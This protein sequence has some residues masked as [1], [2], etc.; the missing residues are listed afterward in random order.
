MAHDTKEANRVRQKRHRDKKRAV[1]DALV[2]KEAQVR[3]SAAANCINC[4]SLGK[5]C[6]AHEHETN[7]VLKKLRLGTTRAS[8]FARKKTRTGGDL[9]DVL[10]A[11]GRTVGR[12]RYTGPSLTFEDL[13]G[14]AGRDEFINAI[15]PWFTEQ[16]RWL[17]DEVIRG[18]PYAD[19]LSIAHVV[20]EEAIGLLK[21]ELAKE[22]PA[23]S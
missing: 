5:P 16:V 12:S 21:T 8:H 7:I 6:A 2:S 14:S 17:T 22:K 3:L 18:N 11:H 13:N 10:P 20:R 1:T 15:L 4:T 19:D 9:P 23:W